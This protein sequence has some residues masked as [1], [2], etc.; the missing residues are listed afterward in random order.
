MKFLLISC[1]GIGLAFATG[2]WAEG[3]LV[4]R[5]TSVPGVQANARLIGYASIVLLIPLGAEV[6]T[7]VRLGLV[8]HALIGFLLV[9]PLLVKLGSV[10]YRFI[11]YYTGN[12]QYRLAGPPYPLMRVLGAGLVLITIVLFAT[13]IELWLF[14]FRYGEQWVTWHKVAFVLWLLGITVHVVAYLPRSAELTL[15]D[16]RTRLPG[17]PTR[18]SLVIAGIALGVGLLLAMVPFRSPFMAVFGGG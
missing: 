1:L 16:W 2:L 10:G 17:A 12:R 18:L 8:A 9:P 5:H 4:N 14:G 15:A 13:G 6:L 3:R 11:R 7:G